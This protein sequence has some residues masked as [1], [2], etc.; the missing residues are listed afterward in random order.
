MKPE[1]EINWNQY[2]FSKPMV[3]QMHDR[4]TDDLRIGNSPVL[5]DFSV[6]SDAK[7]LTALAIKAGVYD[8]Y[9]KAYILLNLGCLQ[10]LRVGVAVN[11]MG[12]VRMTVRAYGKK[13]ETFEIKLSFP[14][15][16]ALLE[17]LDIVC[18][19]EVGSTLETLSKSAYE[20]GNNIYT[21]DSDENVIIR[22]AYRFD[23]NSM[24]VSI[25]AKSYSYTGKPI[26][27]VIKV[28][29]NDDS[30]VID[31]EYILV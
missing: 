5:V 30:S 10:N 22:R 16:V 15:R 1:H 14:E 24:N 13:P 12:D 21:P 4:V 26:K 11:H 28:T 23:E 20:A 29:D 7:K 3:V 8:K 18:M 2:E 27:P 6:F 17:C 31:L 9:D 19:R 25:P